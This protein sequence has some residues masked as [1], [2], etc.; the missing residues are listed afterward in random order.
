MLLCIRLLSFLE[1][2]IEKAF[3]IRAYKSLM[4]CLTLVF[5]TILLT[6]VKTLVCA[7]GINN[8]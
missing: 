5:Y 1:F 4:T 2:D 3:H 6:H 7:Y 8:S